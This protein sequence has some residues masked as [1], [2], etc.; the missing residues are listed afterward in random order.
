MGRI[1]R[2][3]RQHHRPASN[4]NSFVV[5]NCVT[6]A[7][8]ELPATGWAGTQRRRGAGE[9]RTGAPVDRAVHAAA[10]GERRIRGVDD[11]VDVERRDV[12]AENLDHV[13]SGWKRKPC[14][15]VPVASDLPP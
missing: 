11:R 2:L 5:Y 6:V 1:A 10:A 4:N 13:R 9:S 8:D 3:R 14:S 7:R 15:A 12:R